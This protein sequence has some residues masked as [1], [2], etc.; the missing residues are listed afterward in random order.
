MVFETDVSG[1]SIGPF[2]MGSIGSPETLVSNRLTPCYD[3]E[4]GRTEFNRGGS[5][6]SC[7]LGGPQNAGIFL[8]G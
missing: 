1:L 7:N 3:R 4:G 8:T 6:R 2:K 5:L